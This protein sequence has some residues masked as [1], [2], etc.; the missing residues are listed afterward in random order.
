MAKRRRRK[1]T[2]KRTKKLRRVIRRAAPKRATRVRRA[3]RARPKAR[4]QARPKITR[5][6][7]QPRPAPQQQLQ[8]TIPEGTEIGHISHY[9]SGID[10]GIIEITNGV[11]RQ[12]DR[13]RIKGNTT[14]FTQK[15]DSMQYEHQPVE[16]A[17]AGKSVGVKVDQRVREHDKVYV[18]RWTRQAYKSHSVKTIRATIA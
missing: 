4:P 18:L 17:G 6:R 15:V 8:A 13:I 5:M 9:F 16:E 12:G 7:A 3:P 1:A 2:P 10:V 11:L 14:D